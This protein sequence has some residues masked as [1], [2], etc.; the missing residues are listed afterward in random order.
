MDV[1]FGKVRAGGEVE[2]AV[3]LR[4]RVTLLDRLISSKSYALSRS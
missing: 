2:Q 4:W 3:K 1:A